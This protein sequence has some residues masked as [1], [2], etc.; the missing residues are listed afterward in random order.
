MEKHDA[1]LQV[2]LERPM[3]EQEALNEDYN[4]EMPNISVFKNTIHALKSKN[5]KS[6][7]ISTIPSINWLRSYNWR[8]NII[9]DIISGLTVAVMHIPQG[10]AYALLGNVPPVVGIYMA[11]FPV[12][13]YFFFG[14]S[15]HVSIGT[16]AVV[17]LMTGKTVMTYSIPHY[18]ESTTPN[19]TD[20]MFN[21]TKEHLYMYTPMQVAT[22][23]TFM[24]GIYQIIMY[25][26]HLGII[27]TLLSEP[28][29]NSFTTGAA[30]YVF[31]SQIK[32]LLGLKLPKQKGY[33]KLIFTFIDI[34]KEIR[35]TNIAAVIVSL[36]TITCLTFN[37]EFLK[38]WA[39]KKCSIPI[40]I[41]LIAVVSGTLTSK[42]LGLSKE[43]NIQD[44]GNIPTGLPSPA[45]PTFDLLH[46]VAIDS[47]AITMVSYTITISM[48][49]IFA[50]KLKYKINSNQELLAMGMSNIFG[51]FF[52]CMPVSASLSRSLI[53]QTVG[54]RTQIAS[55]VSCLIL[56]TILLWIGP[57]F[58]PLPR[59]V[60]AS[61]IVVALKGMF[62]QAK[63]L[64]KFWKLNKYD[65]L[66]WIATF[67]MVVV[68]S[69]DIG[70]LFGIMLSLLI[71][72]LQSIRPYTCLLGHIPNT[73][74][75]LDLSR[76]KAAVEIPGLKIFQYCGTL[77]FANSNHFKSE[78][79]KRVGVNPHNVIE[80]RL[81]LREKGI[82]IDT[83]DS[84]DKQELRC[85]VMDMSALSYI[86]SSGVVAL[87][88]TITEFN[89]ID[90]NFF[91]VNCSSPIF[92]MIKKCDLYL[93][94]KLTF[95]IF[96]TIRDAKMY[97]DNKFYS[98]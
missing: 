59:C 12:L 78:L 50:Q 79:Y 9:S 47:I 33:F 21:H 52:S 57:F 38:P 8:K 30:V 16:F 36:I 74:L 54:G 98:R 44:V 27:S 10:M 26:F 85:I 4:Y 68:V 92:E 41:E 43:Y 48:A 90:V 39:N 71:I 7:M 3:Y 31:V 93:H 40:P 95:K 97:L 53:Q 65:A 60:L 63:Q 28:L 20:I 77:N 84:E 42:Y 15:R 23:V 24:V 5:W 58:E 73:D 14:T 18:D 29:V 32:D 83:G 11:F 46:L 49:L 2:H 67:L 66:I 51:S 35:N 45:I 82:Y 17:C 81:K 94:G 55:I 19:A 13:V 1:L 96:P 34:I 75:Y 86:D 64:M 22:A 56:L 25:I 37:N 6:C 69:I 89:Q 76:Y 80:H 62:Q 91:F 87:H 88:S 61:I 72:L 70:L